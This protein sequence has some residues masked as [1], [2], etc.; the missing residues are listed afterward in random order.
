M[1]VS[2]LEHPFL[3]GLL[4][5]EAV[6]RFFSA[7]E[8]LAAM[9]AFER[10]LAKAEADAGVISNAARDAVLTALEKTTFDLDALCV[11]TATDGVVVPEFLRQIKEKLPEEHHGALHFGATSQDVIDTSLT[12]RLQG[13]LKVIEGELV[14]LVQELAELKDKYAG[15]EIIGRTRM[16]QALPIPLA[17]RFDGWHR[18][19]NDL[20]NEL[21]S[22]H[23]KISYLQFAGAVGTLD[24]LGDKAALVRKN[25]AA[26]LSL[27][28]P[29][30]SWHTDRRRLMALANWLSELTGS[31]GKLGQDVIQMAVNEVQEVY[32][33]GSGGSSA[34][35]H[36]QNPV[37]GEV[38][39]TL[40]RFNAMNI[41]G[42]HQALLHE[43][44]RSGSSWTLE[45]M[46]LPQMVVT[47]A[48]SIRRAR[49]LLAQID[50][51]PDMD[52]DLPG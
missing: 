19:L 6:A 47:G 2:T 42:M 30:G 51:I 31:I 33:I 32:L 14:G 18:P 24:K 7:E 44:E 36:K 37:R 26:E 13:A 15:R 10:G 8:D 20:L 28:D 11:S 17:H 45:W 21:A 48:A 46:V 35:P 39:V 3:K 40:A 38:L 22:V 52:K 12:I 50:D 49:E 29:M 9:S 1:T 16:Q 27:R 23:E 4:G 25:L 5:Q 43:N 41:S 34:M